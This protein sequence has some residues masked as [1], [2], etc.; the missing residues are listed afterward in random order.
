MAGGTEYVEATVGAVGRVGPDQWAVELRDSDD[1][2]LPIVIGHCEAR[3][4]GQRAIERFDPQRPLTQDL[5]VALWKRLGGTL[6]RLQIDDLFD[7]TYYGK[8]LFEQ[9]DRTV[10]V[11]CRPS[12]G[13]ALALTA[14]VP[15]FVADSVMRQGADG[16]SREEAD[17]LDRWLQSLHDE[18]ETDEEDEE[19]GEDGEDDEEDEED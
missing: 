4:I 5:A 15:I 18:L 10:E 8:L 6:V 12:D 19:D 3:A 7:G 16:E 13:L 14:E 2:W 1:R 9:D 11:D 17:T